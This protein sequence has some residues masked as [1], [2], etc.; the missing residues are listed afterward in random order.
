M[1]R[2]VMS[3]ARVS[4][5]GNPPERLSSLILQDGFARLCWNVSYLSYALVTCTLYTKNWQGDDATGSESSS[6]VVERSKRKR[7]QSVK[8]ILTGVAEGL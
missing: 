4:V 1:A 8:T 2:I 3:R 7:F 6:G 5:V